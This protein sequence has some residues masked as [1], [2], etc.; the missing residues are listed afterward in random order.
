[1]ESPLDLGA[2]ANFAVQ[3]HHHGAGAL[4]LES[5]VAPLWRRFIFDIPIA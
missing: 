3:P 5:L 1:M 4:N 2:A